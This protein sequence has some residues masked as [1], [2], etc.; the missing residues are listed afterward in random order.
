MKVYGKASKFFFFFDKVNEEIVLH[1][2]FIDKKNVLI[3]E[4]SSS[5]SY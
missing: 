2:S 4:G 5:F 1:I 3:L